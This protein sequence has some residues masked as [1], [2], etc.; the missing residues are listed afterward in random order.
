MAKKPTKRELTEQLN[1]QQAEL[2]KICQYPVGN[3]HRDVVRERELRASIA[4][5]KTALKG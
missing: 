1:A 3:V 4:E 5:L 2:R